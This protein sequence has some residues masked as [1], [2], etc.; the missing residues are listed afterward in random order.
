LRHAK[1]IFI[2]PKF[3]QNEASN[4]CLSDCF[5]CIRI[6]VKFIKVLIPAGRFSSVAVLDKHLLSGLPCGRVDEVQAEEP[7]D[8]SKWPI[9]RDWPFAF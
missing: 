5:M 1:T 9:P 3:G 7:T 4:G 8:T 2:D 6:N